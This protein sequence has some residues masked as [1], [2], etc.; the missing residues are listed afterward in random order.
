MITNDDKIRIIQH[1]EKHEE[2]HIVLKAAEECSKLAIELLTHIKYCNIK[3]GLHLTVEKVLSEVVDVHIVLVA[4]CSRLQIPIKEV[5]P[6]E[7]LEI[8]NEIQHGGLWGLTSGIMDTSN[9]LLHLSKVLIQSITKRQSIS[10]REKILS[11]QIMEIYFHL[12]KLR[13]IYF[14]SETLFKTELDKKLAKLSE[15]NKSPGFGTLIIK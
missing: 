10:E 7:K 6:I 13:I 9:Q 5:S 12:H 1:I 2:N 4:L 3:S 14:I 15:L 8:D 11:N